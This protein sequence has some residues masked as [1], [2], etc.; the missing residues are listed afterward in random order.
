MTTDKE[1]EDAWWQRWREMGYSWEGLAKK[2]DGQGITLQDY[3]RDEE[4]RLILDPT[5]PEKKRRYTRFHLPLTWSDGTPTEKS[6]WT[7]DEHAGLA[8]DLEARLQQALDQDQMALFSGVVLLQVPAMPPPK[9]AEGSDDAAPAPRGVD[10]AF[11]YSW[12][13]TGTKWHHQVFGNAWFSGAT[14]SGRAW[15]GGATFSGLTWFEDATFSGLAR[16]E[17]ATF[18]GDARFEDA[19]FS[20]DAGFDRCRFQP[21]DPHSRR[22]SFERARFLQSFHFP[23]DAMT[24][25][26]RY[27]RRA[28]H[29]AKFDGNLY[30]ELYQR[31]RERLEGPT[32]FPLGAFDGALFKELVFLDKDYAARKEDGIPTFVRQQIES[33]KTL[34]PDER[35]DQLNSIAEGARVLQIAMNKGRNHRAEQLFHKIE[36][37]A[38]RETRPWFSTQR[39]LTHLY[40][41]TSDFGGS[42]RRPLI[43]LGLVWLVC[44]LIYF[45]AALTQNPNPDNEPVPSTLMSR[46]V[47][48]AADAFALSTRVAFRPTYVLGIN[49][50]TGHNI[51][52]ALFLA[53]EVKGR[54]KA[55]ALGL[56]A[57]AQSIFSLTMLFL[58][59]LAAR[60]YYQLS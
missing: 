58:T 30:T 47:E 37:I 10:V 3:W 25:D 40:E 31:H 49:N 26:A 27:C 24:T 32:P 6:T 35:D 5:D 59:G 1:R 28:F 16:F 46:S 17:D 38:Q 13:N 2:G 53:P 50:R 44:G 36:L 21:K 41:W 56:L 39:I 52:K 20:G 19:T 15:F 23:I 51:E 48:T 45:G 4:P 42:I 55:V 43:S 12:L 18:S 54:T 29:S 60:R 7:E 9:A 34:P 11:G 14:F 8:R 33:T 22:L 57:F